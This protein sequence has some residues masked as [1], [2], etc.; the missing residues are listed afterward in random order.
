MNMKYTT[1]MIKLASR[2]GQGSAATKQMTNHEKATCGTVE[3]CVAFML[4]FTVC[5]APEWRVAV[6]RRLILHFLS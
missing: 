6:T 4:L 5:S 1:E 3:N 2:I